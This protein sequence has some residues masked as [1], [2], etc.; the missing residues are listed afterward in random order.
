[1]RRAAP[2]IVLA[3]LAAGCGHS[4][5][6]GAPT[7]TVTV[8]SQPTTTGSTTTAPAQTALR[9]Y[10]LRDGKVAPVARTVTAAPNVAELALEQLGTGPTG[11]E[12]SQGLTTAYP[13]A[14]PVTRISIDNGVATVGLA[15]DL[16]HPALAQLVYT[17][18]QFPTVRSVRTTRMVSDAPSLTRATFEDLTPQI[19]VESPLPGADVTSPLRVTGTANTFE[20]TFDLEI[21]NSSNVKI[22]W[23][24]VTATSGSGTRG[25]YDTTIS[26]PH[27]GGALTL[28]AY[29]PSAANGR[30]IHVVRI[31][32]EQP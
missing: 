27:T 25:T 22:A 9:I 31:P 4:S 17:L 26:F 28:V 24:F 14:D 13:G 29:E 15:S 5:R 6:T 20:A 11:A 21:R 32:L 8:P 10:L 7:V 18:T 16:S 23:R 19:L 2:L 30:P 3:A 12:R 1:M